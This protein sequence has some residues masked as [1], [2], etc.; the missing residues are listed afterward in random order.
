MAKYTKRPDGRYRADIHLGYA[1]D[2]KR[3]RKTFYG[4]TQRELDAK[5]AE[6]KSL[7]NKGIIISDNNITLAEWALKWLNTYRK[8]DKHNTKEM[9]RR[10]VEKHIITA[11]IAK[12]PISKIKKSDLQEVVNAIVA[13][14]YIR[15]AQ[16]VVLT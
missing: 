13:E 4:K 12:L 11:N 14:G 3:L 10:C 7:K 9:Y 5:L 6:F 1:P 8:E 15:T 2:G 16:I